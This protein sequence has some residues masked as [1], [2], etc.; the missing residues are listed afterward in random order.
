MHLIGK[1][2]RELREQKGINQRE[3]AELIEIDAAIISHLE[4]DRR[5]VTVSH[6]IKLAKVFE[7]RVDDL[8]NVETLEAA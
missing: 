6:A 1:R 5:G 3:L 7:I 8:L 2:L 4:Q